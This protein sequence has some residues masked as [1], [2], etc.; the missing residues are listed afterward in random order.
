MLQGHVASAPEV[1]LR[2]TGVAL[3]LNPWAMETHYTRA[4]A[5][6]RLGAAGLA[7]RTLRAAIDREPQNFVPWALLGDLQV[8]LGRVAEARRSYAR[9]LQL[10]PL[11]PALKVPVADPRRALS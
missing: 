1:A 10:N 9:A 2:E 6:A 5:F 8:R 3:G 11:E 7:E 4:A